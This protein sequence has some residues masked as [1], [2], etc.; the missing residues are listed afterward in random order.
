MFTEFFTGMPDYAAVT[1]L[2][3]A[4]KKYTPFNVFSIGR[5]HLGREIYAFAT[6][7]LSGATVYVGCETGGEWPASL[8]LYKFMQDIGENL[9]PGGEI[10]DMDITRALENRTLVIIPTLNPE[11]VEAVSEGTAENKESAERIRSVLLEPEGA[12][13][14][15]VVRNAGGRA[16]YTAGKDLLGASPPEKPGGY[17]KKT[18]AHSRA[19]TEFCQD[20]S[21]KKLFIFGEGAR[22]ICYNY[23]LGMSEHSRIS[24]MVLALCSGLKLRHDHPS[25]PHGSLL[26]WYIQ[27]FNRPG[28]KIGFMPKSPAG[29][30]FDIQSEYEKLRELLMLGLLV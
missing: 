9:R 13:G 28:F 17:E 1:K 20:Y 4:I 5:T 21:P 8:L 12:L 30:T 24:A 3:P 29:R 27:T 14:E 15:A 6:G 11:A 16:F 22:E 26:A 7:P 2:L 23:P 18:E 10:A 19:I 25:I